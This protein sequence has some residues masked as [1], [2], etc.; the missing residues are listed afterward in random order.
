L[1]ARSLR[2]RNPLSQCYFFYQNAFLQPRTLGELTVAPMRDFGLGTHFELQ[3]GLLERQEGVRAQLEYNPDLFEPN[4]IRCMLEDYQKILDTMLQSLD[5]RVDQLGVSVR[6]KAQPALAAGSSQ[7]EIGLPQNETEKQLKVIWEELLG[8]RSISV[9]QN[10]FELGGNSILAVR[11]FAQIENVFKVKLP[12]STL[13][14][15]PTIGQLAR[16][17]RTEGAGPT[18]SPVV[19]MQPK[20]SRPPFFCVHAAGGNVLLYRDLSRHLGTDQ[21]F[22]G[23]QFP[24][25]DGEQPLLT[26]IE[27]MAALY[28]K[29]IQRVQRHGPYF[30]GGYCLGGTIALEMAQQLTRNS[31]DVALLALFD[32]LN[33][34]KIPPYSVWS[35]AYHQGERLV[36]HAGNFM[37]LSFKDK[38]K[39][40][41][42]KLKVLRSR[43]N[44]W[45]GM[46]SSR[47]R[48]G[49]RGS[50]SESSLLAQIWDVTDRASVRY[51]AQPYPGVI[52]DFRPMKQYRKYLGPGVYWDGLAREG[53]ETVVLPVYPAG[54]LLEPFVKHLAA[55]LRMSMDRAMGSAPAQPMKIRK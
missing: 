54:M 15:A 50:R 19:P 17:L 20:G 46:L 16:V 12:L 37:L 14:E 28:V 39:F 33:W 9:H 31:E 2:G 38:A 4:T 26:R 45:R 10:Y 41:Q 48:K 29:E 53:Y 23:L 52:T 42:E 34:S 21:P 13:I 22:Y 3:M 49:S 36:F 6:Q 40:F 55:E 27:D 30:L 35:K 51:V 8:I 32:T 24:G 43:S 7:S 44:I 25:L 5:V 47:L 18:W 11:L 1:D